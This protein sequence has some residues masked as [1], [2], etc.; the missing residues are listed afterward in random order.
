MWTVR[1]CWSEH[2]ILITGFFFRIAPGKQFLCTGQSQVAGN[3][4]SFGL[5]IRMEKLPD[6]PPGY[7]ISEGRLAYN[8]EW[9]ETTELQSD[10]E[11][12]WYDF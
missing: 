10:S 5:I 9:D 2:E 6:L 7:S 3:W 12:E 8:E 4:V 11:E 1:S